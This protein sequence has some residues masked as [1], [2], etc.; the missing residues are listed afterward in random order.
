[1]HST[2]PP[3]I[4]MI[5]GIVLGVFGMIVV[6]ILLFFFLR[7]RKQQQG[8]NNGLEAPGPMLQSSVSLSSGSYPSNHINPF[9]TPSSTSTSMSSPQQRQQ[10]ITNEMRLVRKQME[11]L[12][13]TGNSSTYSS[14]APTSTFLSSPVFSSDT[15]ALDLERSRQQ[16]DAL[17]SRIAQLEDQLQSAWA[18]GLSNDPPPGYVA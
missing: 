10:H 16:N 8:R 14:S 12:R 7:R 1:M 17:Q 15:N 4:G 13:R 9:M 18:L 5:I 3:P 6:L 2:S 11:E